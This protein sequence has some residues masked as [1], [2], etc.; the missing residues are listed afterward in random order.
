MGD[1]SEYTVKNSGMIKLFQARE[2]LVS[3]IPA[4]DG[5]IDNLFT[6]F[7]PANDARKFGSYVSFHWWNGQKLA[8]EQLLAGQS[9]RT[10]IPSFQPATKT[11]A[12][13]HSFFSR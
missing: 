5:K 13:M 9:V 4:G 12:L 8:A 1:K 6:V 7:S 3:D 10:A 2:I 11:R